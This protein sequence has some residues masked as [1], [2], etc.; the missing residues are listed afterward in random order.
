MAPTHVSFIASTCNSSSAN[1]NAVFFSSP[2]SKMSD[3]ITNVGILEHNETAGIRSVSLMSQINWAGHVF[4]MF[5]FQ[6]RKIA[7]HGE[8]STGQQSKR[9]P[10]KKYKDYLKKYFVPAIS[11]INNR[12][13]PQGL[14][15]HQLP[16]RRLL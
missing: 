14:A 16:G 8:L 12:N 2:A 5:D 10:M 11:T 13:K 7:I 15:T 9:A 6:P 3:F 1:M 4:R